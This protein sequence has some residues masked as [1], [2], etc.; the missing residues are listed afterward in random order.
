MRKREVD[1]RG[2]SRGTTGDGMQQEIQAQANRAAARRSRSN[3]LAKR[4]LI[5]ALG[6]TLL[7]QPLAGT[8]PFLG[9]T[10]GGS[11]VAAAAV[12]TSFKQT[13]ESMITA[14]A[15]RLDYI[16]T[17]TRSGKSVQAN[18]HVIEID[19][20]N[21]HV[22]LNVMS[23]KNNNLTN[24]NTTT[25]MAKE[26]GAVA[27]VN[28]DY[29]NMGA[30][31]VPMGAQI[32]S[33]SLMSSPSVLK[34][35][36][37]FAISNDRI[38]VIDQFGFEGTVS[39]AS[40]GSFPLAGIN[41]ASYTTEPASGTGTYSHVNAMYI[42]TS[43]WTAAERPNTKNSA[44]TPTEILV[45]NGV[46][47]QVA[48][49]GTLPVQPPA[50]GYILRT[51]GTA[52]QFAKQHLTV[53]QTVNA[54]YNLTSLST[55]A[56]KDPGSYQMMVGG[57]TILINDGKAASFSRDV[58]SIS[59]NSARSRT[60][61]GY[62][63][64]NKKVYMVTV[65]D[66]GNS[67]GMTL[68][69]LQEVMV[70]LGVWKGL[71]LDGGGSTTMAARP[72]GE[73]EVGLAHPT[74]NSG[75]TTERRVINGIG[76]YTSAP[77][78]EV[79]GIKASGPSI[80]FLGQSA[81]YSLK[82]Y[83]TYYNPIEPTGMTAQWSV[84]G[85]GAMNGSTFTPSRS[86]K[87]T[88]TVKSG[89]ASDKLAVEVI[90]A[91]QISEM[92]VAASSASLQAGASI[93]VPVRIKLTDGREMTLPAE[94]VRWELSGFTGEVKDGVLNVGQVNQGATS[95]TAIA[96]YDG[97]SALVYFA[98]GDASAE[99][100]WENFEN[101][102]Y[103]ITFQATPNETKGSVT[104]GNSLSGMQSKGLIINYDFTAGTGTKAAYAALNGDGR[105]VDGTPLAISADIYGDGSGNWVRAE[106]TDAA[107]KLHY[108]DLARPL[109]WT[110]WRTVKADLSKLGMTYP[111]KV[112]RLYVA[113]PEQGQSE[114]AA[115]G[116][117]AIDNIGFHYPAS[118][119]QP[120][121]PTIK[122][123]LGK[124]DATIGGTATKLDVAPVA[125][126]GVTYLPLKFVSDA[127]KGNVAWDNQ[128]KR[129]TFLRGDKLLELWLD[130]KSY[131][132]NGKRQ[133]ALAAPI[134]RN[135]RTLVPVR[136]VSEQLGLKVHYDAVQ[137]I[138]TIQ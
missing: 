75:G 92:T 35:M 71:N 65:E 21:P 124:T 6:G 81:G 98:A 69:E 36:Y 16:W 136:L 134:I 95:G 102:A 117:I 32:I 51:H 84:E 123:T 78:G 55:G 106:V 4:V 13:T 97:Y 46:V 131:V 47:T 83:D 119:V 77:K 111:V 25:N 57:H 94:S 107:G 62:S 66:Y 17:G 19:L 135:N 68:K 80:V 115:T 34:G 54:N 3:K 125:L 63:R 1:R 38:P 82:A 33:G 20:T 110:G 99:R 73:F 85:G 43:A 31:G 109:D 44:T 30:E 50:N 10:L 88:L 48:E 26:T 105:A 118:A 93:N 129:A 15:K 108:V 14:G 89:S 114:R 9:H 128:A 42:Y 100:T 120:N 60:A 127:I 72:L 64:D 5:I 53:G 103:P 126:N 24:T 91:S 90:G 41:Q 37:A 12:T 138:I 28:A 45:E 96:R 79:R 76:V 74:E 61:V 87:T 49:G 104:I 59:G 18:V 39:T 29:F 23:G 113:N 58:S 11:Q 67:S 2:R 7:L 52:A 121:T 112:K 40:G 101:V 132:I 27:G 137:K 116:Q 86:G 130:Q 56:K 133:E 122:M 70:R 22:S 8:S